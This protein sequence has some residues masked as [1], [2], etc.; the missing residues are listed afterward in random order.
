M[1]RSPERLCVTFRTGPFRFSY[2]HCCQDLGR[3]ALGKPGGM[4]CC[5]ELRLFGEWFAQRSTNRCSPGPPRGN[6]R[7]RS[8]KILPLGKRTYADLL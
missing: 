7:S 5:S 6:V 8:A 2:N 3:S 4:N 1:K